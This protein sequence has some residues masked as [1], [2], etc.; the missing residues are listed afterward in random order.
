MI[1]S[2]LA[3]IVLSPLNIMMDD[4][5]KL[6]VVVGVSSRLH[7][8]IFSVYT[9]HHS[10]TNGSPQTASCSGNNNSLA[11]TSSVRSLQSGG[12]PMLGSTGLSA[13]CGTALVRNASLGDVLPSLPRLRNSGELSVPLLNINVLT[14]LR[15]SQSGK[16]TRD[17]HATENRSLPPSLPLPC[18][19]HHVYPF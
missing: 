4:I 18:S 15:G 6:S 2:L 8:A 19:P 11:S 17:K 12:L 5:R 13:N 10:V 9:K 14:P 7:G 3:T 1:L 16:R